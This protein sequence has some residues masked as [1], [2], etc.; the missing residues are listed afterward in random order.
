LVL[1]SVEL[2]G[3][4]APVYLATDQLFQIIGYAGLPTP[5]DD[6]K[7][8]PPRKLG[9]IVDTDPFYRLERARRAGL[10]WAGHRLGFVVLVGLDDAG[11]KLV[12]LA[13][14]DVFD[15]CRVPA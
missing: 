9:A 15:G 2:P 6:G 7:L 8:T 5:G 11:E 10:A 12:E 1:P 3:G 4:A 14:H 13:R